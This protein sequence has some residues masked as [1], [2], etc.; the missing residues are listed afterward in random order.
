MD[1]TSFFTQI[2]NA[3][4]GGLGLFLGYI[5]WG[6]F[7]A[8]FVVVLLSNV[9]LPDWRQMPKILQWFSRHRY[10]VPALAF[11]MAIVFALLRDYGTYSRALWFTYTTTMMFSMVMNT[12][13]LDIP[14]TTLSNKYPSWKL[15]FKGRGTDPDA[16]EQ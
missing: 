7:V 8:I 6:F 10:R 13:F 3:V 15:V 2:F 4:S 5:Y 12:W 16:T 14:A 9:L 1:E 11:L